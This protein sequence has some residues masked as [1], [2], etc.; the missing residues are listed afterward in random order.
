MQI[1][2]VKKKDVDDALK[3]RNEMQVDPFHSEFASY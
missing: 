1:Q 3:K 2:C